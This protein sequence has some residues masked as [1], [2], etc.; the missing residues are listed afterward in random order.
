[1]AQWIHSWADSMDILKMVMNLLKII[2][3]KG[4]YLTDFH[5]STTDEQ[6]Y[7]QMEADHFDLSIQKL[8]ILY[9]Q[10][11]Q[12]KDAKSWLMKMN[13]SHRLSTHVLDYQKT[14]VDSLELNSKSYLTCFENTF[15]AD[16]L[17][18]MYEFLKPSSKFW[19]FHNY[20]QLKSTGYFSYVYPLNMNP[21]NF[22]EHYIQ[23]LFA[24]IKETYPEKA[25]K[26]KYAEW[27]AHCRPH[28]M[29]HQMH[30][31]S[32]D[33]G[34]G[35]VRHPLL[36]TVLYVSENENV[37]GPT[38]MTNQKLG[39]DLANKGWLVF[40]KQ[41]RLSIFDANYLHGVVP[42]KLITPDSDSRR[43][44]F[45]VGFW[46]HITIKD[47]PTFGSS[48]PLPTC[49]PWLD[50][51]IPSQPFQLNP[52]REEVAPIPIKSVWQNINCSPLKSHVLP[53]YEGC[54]QGF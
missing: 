4:Q 6:K 50:S 24:L 10:S 43:I 18:S 27:W 44:T 22:I 21:R 30:Y 37:G 40:P 46:D 28:F 20:N 12:N 41:N 3:K 13:Y 9:C 52:N 23:T 5:D 36:S 35:T 14:S 26:I 34:N 29:G 48:R 53:D 33:E 2:I 1:M 39:Q 42:G 31:D 7:L 47:E 19:S 54:F 32:E 11:S 17:T 38:L 51:T 16:L 8:I 25:K 49:T 15:N 45:M